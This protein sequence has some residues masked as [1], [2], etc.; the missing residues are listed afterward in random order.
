MNIA[1]FLN[2]ISDAEPCGKY[3]CYEH[4]YDQIKELRREDDPQ[5]S[6]GIWQTEPKKAN[7]LELTQLCS[8]LLQTETKDLQIVMWLTEALIAE[9]GFQGLCTGLNLI[10]DLC[11]TFW[12]E[13]FPSI[14]WENRN[15]DYRLAPFFFLADKIPDRIVLIPLTDTQHVVFHN[16]SDWMMARRNLQI[17]NHKG[18]SLKDIGK[19]V[20]ISSEQFFENIATNVSQSLEWLRKIKDFLNEQCEQESPSFQRLEN[21][22][23]DIKRITDKNLDIKKK[24]IKVAPKTTPLETSSSQEERALEAAAIPQSAAENSSQE[25][26][27]EQAYAALKE[28][29]DFLEKKQPQSPAYTL[30]KIAHIIGGKNFHELLE[31]N[32]SGG[33][34]VLTTIAELY[35][36]LNHKP[37]EQANPFGNNPNNFSGMSQL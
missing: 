3:L 28:I 32:M 16:L 30:V 35:R 33:A 11:E 13:I 15:Y 20:A 9:K 10:H 8:K 26:T 29:A 36:I 14:D 23:E 25:P 2:P 31:L 4:V 17:K 6:Q 5:L 19:Q 12:D 18:L 1:D 27:I 24:Q 22:L 37:E 7:W 21:M 34:S